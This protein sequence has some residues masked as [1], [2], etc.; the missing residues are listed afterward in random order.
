VGRLRGVLTRDA[1]IR[2]LQANGPDA[3]VL[4]AMDSEIPTISARASLE[5]ALKTLSGE[6]KPVIGVTDASGK[7]VGMLTAENLGEMMM[8]RS[9]RSARAARASETS[10]TSDKR[11]P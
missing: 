11:G 6:S 8:V 7:L 5:A 10:G 9:A 2:A 1:M 4:E 3:P